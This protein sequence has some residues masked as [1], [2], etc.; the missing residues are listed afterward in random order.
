MIALPAT[1]NFNQE[2]NSTA[3]I[4]PFDVA[5]KLLGYNDDIT[6]IGVKIKQNV[7]LENA[8]INLQKILG[9]DY[10]VKTSFEK[11]ALIFKT[12]K[13]EKLIVFC[14]LI[15]IFI[16]ACFNMVAAL[17]MLFIE[18]K[19]NMKTM[20]SFGVQPFSVF[21]IFFFQGCMITF[22]GVFSG[23]ILGYSVVCVQYFGK[24][25]TIPN[26]GGEIFP[27]GVKVVDVFQIVFF[28]IGIACVS[29][30][31]TVKILIKGFFKE[32]NLGNSLL[33]K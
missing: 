32:N 16:L 30:W 13:M 23:L 10:I 25:L 1:I 18:K 19:E 27:V 9:K 15:F 6:R 4:L 2:V 22:V 12:S 8:K 28:T 17:T 11:N 21:Q 5:S 20:L 14:I 33:K 26:S 3:I 24:V 7:A 29:T 31:I